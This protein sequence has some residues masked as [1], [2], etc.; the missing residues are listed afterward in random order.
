MTRPEEAHDHAVRA[1]ALDALLARLDHEMATPLMTAAG[2][3][4]LA[5]EAA[6]GTVAEQ[7][8]RCLDGIERARTVLRRANRLATEARVVTVDLRSAL[9]PAVAAMGGRLDVT[10]PDAPIAVHGEPAVLTDLCDAVLR[11]VATR[12]ALADG[13]AP[14]EVDVTVDESAG[15]TVVVD[16][17]GG[18]GP[19]PST[20]CGI[21]EECQYSAHGVAVVAPDRSEDEAAVACGAA[22]LATSQLGSI[23]LDPRADP[24]RLVVRLL[25]SDRSL[26]AGGPGGAVD[27]R[28]EEAT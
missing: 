14:G 23:W 27:D 5:A 26:L 3:A 28:S 20:L 18:A 21:V 19:W 16:V 12:S 11:L 22:A 8:E 2:F 15:P 9:A 10:L 13:D 4:Q 6:E 25:R 7:L 1:A 17:V 24:A